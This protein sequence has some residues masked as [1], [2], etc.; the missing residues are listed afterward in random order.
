M[1]YIKLIIRVECKENL[2]PEQTVVDPARQVANDLVQ[3]N[4]SCPQ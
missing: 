2:A 1:V 3:D 4:R